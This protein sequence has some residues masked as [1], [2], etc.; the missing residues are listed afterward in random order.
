VVASIRIRDGG[1]ALADRRVP[2][3]SGEIHFWRH[4]P[5]YWDAL[6]AQVAAEGIPLVSTYLSW[7]RHEPSPGN[8]DLHGSTDPR[9]DIGRFLAL[10]SKHDLL[11]QLKP[12]PWICAEEK[13]G[14]YPDWLLA[15]TDLWE[16]G[17]DGK[18]VLGYNPPFQHHVPCY[19]HPRYLEAS[20][21]WLQAVGERIR[22]QVWPNGPVVMVQL[23][24]EPS[25]CFRDG[26]VEAGHHPITLAAF[27]RRNWDW[28]EFQGWLLAEHLRQIRSTLVRAGLDQVVFTANYNDH[29]VPTVPQDP[30]VLRKAVRGVGG[31]DLYYIPPLHRADIVRLA[32]WAALMV[33]REPVPWVPEAQAGIWRSP[34]LNESHPDPTPAEQ[35]LWYMAALAFGFRGLN[36]YMLADRE[37]WALAPLDS[38]GR[39]SPFRDSVRSAVRV[40][41]SFPDWG[42]MRPLASSRMSWPAAGLRQ[43][44]MGQGDVDQRVLETFEAMLDRGHTVSIGTDGE[45]SSILASPISAGGGALAVVQ[46]GT[47]STA[48]F[49]INPSG[50]RVHV[51]LGGGDQALSGRWLPVTHV[52]PALAAASGRA[53]LDLDPW[54]WAV[55]RHGHGND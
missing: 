50:A 5:E 45:A 20:R 13:C 54:G 53:E 27:R 49:V 9:L 4:D 23:D 3:L 55:F 47:Q 43:T 40:I 52:G 42:S 26:F 46:Q 29:P 24:N 38:Y 10:C 44:W 17:A 12:G 36:F 15:D 22:G 48:I 31:P 34:G 39:P 51:E 33:E 21:A 16:L 41:K 35:E 25:H 6:L 30:V 11:V 32:L 2:L 14:G 1:L 18:P 37:N 19:L 28:A 7:R 8:I